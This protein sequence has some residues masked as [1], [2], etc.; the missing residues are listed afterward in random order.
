MVPRLYGLARAFLVQEF[1]NKLGK[2]LSC[3]DCLVA[4]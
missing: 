3:L 4:E 1:I 2:R